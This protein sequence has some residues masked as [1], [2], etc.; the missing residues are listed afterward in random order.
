[1]NYIN[2]LCKIIHQ[3][4]NLNTYNKLLDLFDSLIIIILFILSAIISLIFLTKSKKMDKEALKQAIKDL[5]QEA[6][7]TV[8]L[9]LE[10]YEDDICHISSYEHSSLENKT[11]EQLHIKQALIN[12]YSPQSSPLLSSTDNLSIIEPTV[13]KEVDTELIASKMAKKNE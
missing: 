3:V 9:P 6:E 11:R 5:K 10:S 2:W 7:E 8:T 12:D 1:M 4:G 13:G